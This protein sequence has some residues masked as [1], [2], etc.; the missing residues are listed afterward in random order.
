M[1]TKVAS[2]IVAVVLLT[3]TSLAQ[4][5][6]TLTNFTSANMR[7]VGPLTQGR[8]G[9]LYG[10]SVLG[11]S[12]ALGSIFKVDAS[13][14]GTQIHNF[15]GPDGANPMDGLTLG[16]DGYLYGT[17]YYGGQYNRGVIY[18][19][20]PAGVLTVLYS[21]TG[22]SD[23]GLPEAPPVQGSDGN[24]YGTTAI[25]GTGGQFG[26]GVVYKITS[27]GQYSVVFEVS[28]SNNGAAQ[29]QSSPVQAID[30]SLNI[31]F[32]G[33]GA[34]NCGTVLQI[35]TSGSLGLVYDFTSGTGGCNPI[36]N[37]IQGSDG[38][39]YG[40]DQ[41]DT[42]SSSTAFKL[43]KKYQLETINTF[44]ESGPNTPN[45]G[46]I[47]GTDG[48]LYGTTTG[49]GAF[50]DGTIYLLSTMGSFTKLYDFPAPT[51]SNYM[52][53]PGLLLQ[54]TNGKFYGQT[55]YGG[56]FGLGSVYELDNGLGPFVALVNPI[57]KAGQGIG[58]L[59]QGF[60]GTTSVTFN[61]VGASAFQVVSDTYINAI[62]PTGVTTG[63]VQ[64]TTP[65]GIL[66][67]NKNFTV[68]SH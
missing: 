68:K 32:R 64:V 4:T 36:G 17:T 25:G 41:G 43:S 23:G 50:Y 47:Q 24:F 30:G 31:L 18:K 38:N 34:Y 61:G 54:H 6:T 28:S 67:S 7:P 15:S 63:S 12:T 1:K 21:F 58:I 10:T 65:T 55:Y 11:G 19:V 2:L 49:G 35:T 57:G 37:L 66:T 33:G 44:T 53:T 51:K 62:A 52:M 20:S 27:S 3:V 59:G 45:S 60:T 46:V 16:T 29:C 56:F 5:V 26:L 8:D 39:F 22:N 48:N 13:G 9:L 14:K 42:S 40:A